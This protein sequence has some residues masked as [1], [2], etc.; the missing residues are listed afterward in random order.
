MT[1]RVVLIVLD[2]AGIGALPDAPAY[3][4]AGSDTLGNLIRTLGTLNIPNLIQLGL[5]NIA[6]VQIP[7]RTDSPLGAFGKAAEASPGKDTTTGH[8]EIGG[9]VLEEPFPVYPG[10]FPEEVLAPFE[11]AVGKKVLW[12]KP[13][14]GS[15]IILQLGEEHAASR[16]P[17]VYTSADS[18]FQIAAHEAVVPLETLYQWC[19]IAREILKPPHGV[20]RVIARPFTGTPGRYVRTKNR[21]DF[22]LPPPGETILTRIRDAGMT[23]SAVGKIEDIFAGQGITRSFPTQS[24][25]EGLEVT[26]SLVQTPFQGLIFTNLVDFDMLYG[27]RNDAAGYGAALEAA[28]RFLPCLFSAL[29]R[30]DVLIITAD[31][32]CDP[33][34]KSTDHSREYVP[35]LVYGQA[36]L[37]GT[38]LGV[39]STFS[40][41]GA[42]VL[43]L[44]GLL[45]DGR[46]G[47]GHSFLG[48]LK[49]GM[50]T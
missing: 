13:A 20:G 48:K 34:T 31:H 21:R 32:G 27:H 17:I 11:Q 41:I 49:K 19:T 3:G 12:N 15:E 10:G 44:L 35:V 43:D 5:G 45:P 22:S 42:T 6:K 7:W 23:V 46:F 24:N 29:R 8:W 30:E 18:V 26:L 4:D 50:K 16:R 2:S 37:P 1:E 14:S 39:L 36:I 33:T 40:D 47:A 9:I 25:Q 28:D 38:D